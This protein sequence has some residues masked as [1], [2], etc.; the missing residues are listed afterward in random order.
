MPQVTH[1]RS[2]SGKTPH[3]SM[4]DAVLSINAR[5]KSCAVANRELIA[6]HCKYCDKY[7]VGHPVRLDES[8]PAKP[9]KR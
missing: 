5:V 6:Y 9:R 1:S 7:H 3:E 2:C 8:K 4:S